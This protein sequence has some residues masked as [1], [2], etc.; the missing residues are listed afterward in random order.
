MM[1]SLRGNMFIRYLI[2][3]CLDIAICIA[4]NCIDISESEEGLRWDSTFYMVNN[5][6]SI[7][8][9]CALMIFPVFVVV[10]YCKSFAK[11]TEESF[12]ERYGAIFEGL[13]KD[14]RSS[15]A[16]PIIFVFRRMVLVIIATVTKDYLI[17]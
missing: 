3:G 1:N 7:V 10:L 4:I 17:V 14:R 5:I 2:E 12:E 9:G 16:Y 13:R 11:W 6:S 8:L 15:L